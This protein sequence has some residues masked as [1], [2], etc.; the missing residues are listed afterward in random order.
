M[1]VKPFIDL[2]DQMEQLTINVEVK[3]GIEF[4][5]KWRVFLGLRVIQL[6]CWLAGI[7]F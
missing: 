6:G 2:L 1:K 3:H 5:N 7:D 4:R